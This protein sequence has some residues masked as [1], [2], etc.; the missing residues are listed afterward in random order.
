MYCN[1]IVIKNQ[2]HCCPRCQHPDWQD[3]AS[4]GFPNDIALLQPV[5]PLVF[6]DF[7]NTLPLDDGRVSLTR[8]CQLVGW[9]IT[10]QWWWRSVASV[11]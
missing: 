11:V 3:V 7:I 8:R 1:W 6:S 4:L 5:T 9:G 2:Y 10:G